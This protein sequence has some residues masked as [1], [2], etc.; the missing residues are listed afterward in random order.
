M[1]RREQRE[2]EKWLKRTIDPTGEELTDEKAKDRWAAL[3]LLANPEAVLDQCPQ[4][5][6]YWDLVFDAVPE[7]SD[8]VKYNFIMFISVD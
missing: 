3:H 6:D 7:W 8:L 1:G 4:Q 5:A 2:I